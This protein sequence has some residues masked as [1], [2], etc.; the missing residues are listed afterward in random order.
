MIDKSS[1]RTCTSTCKLQ[2]L[3]CHHRPAK[4]E[5]AE[6]RLACFYRPCR[7]AKLCHALARR[8][9][10]PASFL[11]C[12]HRLRGAAPRV[13]GCVEKRALRHSRDL[14]PW[15]F[16]CRCRRV[17]GNLPRLLSS[18]DSRH[19]KPTTATFSRSLSSPLLSNKIESEHTAGSKIGTHWV[20]CFCRA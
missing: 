5:R 9:S 8:H 18:C 3:T 2:S 4:A 6:G 10:S 17:S 19:H 1:T 13:L 15:L 14:P 20:R 11:N 16:G 7:R 12:C